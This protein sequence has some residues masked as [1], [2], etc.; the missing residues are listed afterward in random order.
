MGSVSEWQLERKAWSWARSCCQAWTP[1]RK[2]NFG[3][4]LSSQHFFEKTA[5]MSDDFSEVEADVVHYVSTTENREHHSRPDGDG[6][7]PRMPPTKSGRSVWR[8][9]LNNV[10]MWR[11]GARN[12]RRAH[13]MGTC[14]R[15]LRELFVYRHNQKI[16]NLMHCPYLPWTRRPGSYLGLQLEEQ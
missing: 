1:M 6:T 13:P 4:R 5:S 8:K 14:R 9:C 10:E 3:T 15:A 7:S 12:F 2:S 16:D 11:S